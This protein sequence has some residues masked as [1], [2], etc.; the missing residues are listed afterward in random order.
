M[1]ALALQ[2]IAFCMFVYL[3]LMNEVF[4]LMVS[5]FVRGFVFF[6]LEWSHINREWSRGNRCIGVR[7]LQ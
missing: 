3:V 2:V 4:E 7:V 6:F 1:I 5:V